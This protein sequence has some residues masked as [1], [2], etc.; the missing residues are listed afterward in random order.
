MEYRLLK[1]KNKFYP[2]RRKKC[3]IKWRYYS[4]PPYVDKL[5]ANSVSGA[6]DIIEEHKENSENE[7]ENIWKPIVI[8]IEII[9]IIG[10]ILFY[11]KTTGMI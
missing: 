2:Q 6:V 10:I 7:K 3:Q 1:D 5:S 9:I 11:L 8:G 4:G